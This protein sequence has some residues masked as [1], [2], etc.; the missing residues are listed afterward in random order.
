VYLKY[1]L[2]TFF[3]LISKFNYAAQGIAISGIW[4]NASTWQFGTVNRIPTCGDTLFIPSGVTVTISTQLNYSSCPEPMFLSIQGTLHF[5]SGKK[6]DLPCNSSIVLLSGGLLEKDAGGGSSSHIKICSCF[7]W[8]ANQGNLN[9]PQILNCS[10]LP[11]TLLSFTAEE[12][13]EE[14]V[15]QWITASETNND[16]FT[17]ERSQDG[18]IFEAISKII[19]AGNSIVTKEYSLID[20]MPLSGISYYRLR[21]TDY[22]G[23]STVS[24]IVVVKHKINKA[25]RLVS[26]S[27]DENYLLKISLYDMNKEARIRLFEISGREVFFADVKYTEGFNKLNVQLPAL[28]SGSYILMLSNEDEIVFGNVF[29]G[30]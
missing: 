27:V 19:G 29:V 13:N 8:K 6:L 2:F 5:D 25:L 12:K 30:K 3:L 7:S 24:E 4:N 18:N 10:A 21:Q 9:G 11:I 17:I 26:Y 15:L 22:D 28:N 20:N 1:Y 14:I 16:Y 23:H